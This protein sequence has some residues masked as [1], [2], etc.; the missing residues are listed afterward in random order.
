MNCKRLTLENQSTLT[1][2]EGILFQEQLKKFN[3]Y[4]D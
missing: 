1:M 3:D 4:R 2:Q